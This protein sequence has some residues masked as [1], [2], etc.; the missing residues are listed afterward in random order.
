MG[1]IRFLFVRVGG[2]GGAFTDRVGFYADATFCSCQKA[3]NIPAVTQEDHAAKK[4]SHGR[5]R[6]LTFCKRTV[7]QNQ[8]CNDQSQSCPHGP[9]GD[10][11]EKCNEE[12][13]D[14]QGHAK[15]HGQERA[16]HTG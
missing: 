14:R 7:A 12:T 1:W 11:P 5:Q 16:N 15:F 3:R 10:D 8:S 6:S 9:E 4:G 13:K 2:R